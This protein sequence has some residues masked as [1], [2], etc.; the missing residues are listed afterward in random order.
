MDIHALHGRDIL[1][2]GGAGFIGSHLI[3]A[4]I[5]HGATVTTLDHRPA[6]HA[7]NLALVSER[8]KKLQ[9]DLTSGPP[10]DI[11]A[12][13]QYHC[14][15]HLSGSA[16]VEA[17]IKMPAWD[18]ARNT[19]GTVNLLE[20]LRNGAPQ[21]G[22]VFTSSAVVFAGGDETPIKEDDAT[23]PTTPYG[24]SKLACERYI[25]VYARLFGLR[26]TT[27]RLFSVYGP[28]LQ[29]QIVYD[30]M[31]KLAAD[32]ER[33]EV[34]GNG[35]E[36]RDMS[37]VGDVVRG[38]MLIA[39]EAKMSGEAYNLASGT[40][41]TTRHLA[42]QVADSFG[43]SP[44]LRLTG[45]AHV[46]DT[47][48]WHADTSRIRALGYRPQTDLAT[49]IGQTVAWFKSISEGHELTPSPKRTAS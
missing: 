49:G 27:A 47:K 9:F 30:F 16:Q 34:F 6:D 3:E 4:L 14:I 28:R 5:D 43:A 10:T 19:M 35:T 25:A 31:R 22:V 26:T 29:K 20:A 23:H 36:T 11:V 2:T 17:S 15:F 48:Y 33:L 37:Y 45:S 12:R 42:E 38:L 18:L 39:Q 7:P 24:V 44:D 1:V 46:G 32:P 13:G 41:V 8:V 21:T 40:H